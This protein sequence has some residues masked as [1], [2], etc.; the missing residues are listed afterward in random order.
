MS[1]RSKNRDETNRACMQI[2]LK[3]PIETKSDSKSYFVGN[4]TASFHQRSRNRTNIPNMILFMYFPPA[5]HEIILMHFAEMSSTCSLL[6][7]SAFVVAAVAVVPIVAPPFAVAVAVALP[8]PA[9]LSISFVF[10][11]V[12]PLASPALPPRIGH[13]IYHDRQ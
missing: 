10:L 13:A 12:P 7:L 4:R 1:R 5:S 6:K 3:M 9:P 8:R 11:F 2:V